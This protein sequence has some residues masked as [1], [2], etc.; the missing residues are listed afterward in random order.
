MRLVDH[1]LLL[2]SRLMFGDTAQFGINRPERGPLELKSMTGKTPVLDIG[3]L[4]KIKTGHI[5]VLMFIIIARL[6]SL[7]SPDFIDRLIIIKHG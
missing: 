6:I 5:R 3:T 2:V 7:I 1:F 4:A